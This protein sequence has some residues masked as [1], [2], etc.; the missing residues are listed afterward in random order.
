MPGAWCVLMLVCPFI[1]LAAAPVHAPVAH[2][3]NDYEHARPLVE[4]LEN[5]FLSVEADIYLVNGALLVAHDLKDTRPERT[6][7]SLYLDPLAE[8]ARANGGWVN[9]SRQTL[10]LLVD[11]KSEAE[12]TFRALHAVLSRYA[13]ILTTFAEGRLT[14]RAVTVVISGNRSF[15][16][17]A[18]Q[19]PRYASLDGR[20]A[21]LEGKESSELMP[22]ISAHWRS[23]FTWAGEGEI[24]PVELKKLSQLVERTRAQGKQL[25]FW[26]TPD[27]PAV[28][29]E[30]R[31][32]GV[33]IIGT[34]DL[35]GLSRF[36]AQP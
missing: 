4:A 29:K 27:L 33:P 36:L 13:D 17:T 35:T 31:T 34:D 28:W 8:R 6:L 23:Q 19:E 12:T 16:I 14:A 10:I 30:L 1:G 24:P 32:A 26:A 21:D 25:R 3:H 11:V 7:E 20:I 15:A 22:I 5:G 9:E 18:A 2:A